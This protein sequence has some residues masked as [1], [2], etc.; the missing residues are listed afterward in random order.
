[1]Y[2]IARRERF[3]ENSFLW[4]IDAPDVARAAQPGYFVMLRMREGGE[5][6]PL[7]AA[8]FDRKCGTVTVVV[9]ALG[10]TTCE[11]RDRYVEGDSFDAFVGPLG[12]ATVILAMS[13]GRRAARAIAAYLKRGGESWPPSAADMGA[14]VSP[15]PLAS[16][17]AL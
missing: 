12:G 17:A 6:I 7:M 10:K 3:S 13:A 1:V 2:R 5:R 15:T 9:Q 11:M 8:D 4:E 16:A 14:F